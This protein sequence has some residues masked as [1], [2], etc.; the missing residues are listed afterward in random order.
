MVSGGI[1]WIVQNLYLGAFLQAPG[2]PAGLTVIHLL[3]E[4]NELVLNDG[5]TSS[6]TRRMLPRMR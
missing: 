3:I 1:L 6:E 4:G 2:S 5:H